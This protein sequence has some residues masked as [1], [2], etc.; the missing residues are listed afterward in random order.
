MSPEVEIQHNRG[1][2][3]P[4]LELWLD[5]ER[6]V[7]L[8]VISHAHADHIVNH[9][10]IIA[11][12]E[13]A[14]LFALRKG[15]VETE[16]LEYGKPLKLRG[17]TIELFPAGHILGSSQVS[18]EYKRTKIVY[19]GDFKL[20]ESLTCRSAEVKRCDIL[21]MESTYGLPEYVFPETAETRQKIVDWVKDTRDAGEIPIVMAYSLGKAQEAMKLLGD[22]GFDLS[23]HKAI[24]EIAEIYREFGVRFGNYDQWR[25]GTAGLGVVLVPP[26]LSRWK[27]LDAIKKRKKL[28]L[29]GWA[30]DPST[31]Y[32]YDADAVLPLSDHA[33]FT[34]LMAYAKEAKPKKVYVVHGFPELVDYLREEGFDAQP[35]GEE[36]SFVK[37]HRRRK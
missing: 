36:A 32:R 33:D 22:A 28:L 4:E 24:H 16:V 29:T 11:T 27:P 34:D 2:Y 6:K 18:V 3:L 7:D 26:H 10:K 17:A 20:R 15:N 8:S 19:T 25:P 1:L 31:K 23:V 9:K 37:Q 5:A 13:T 21:I 14:R 30:L 12:P 35:L